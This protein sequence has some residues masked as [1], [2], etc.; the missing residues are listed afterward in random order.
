MYCPQ[1]FIKVYIVCIKCVYFPSAYHYVHLSDLLGFTADLRSNTG[2]KAFP[3]C[4]FDHWQLY[5]GDVREEDTKAWKI[6]TDI[7]KRK[8]LK[9]VMSGLE[10]YLDKM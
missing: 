7:R 2:G 8:G 9:E 3:Q 5:P 1:A 6:V 10:N 4:I